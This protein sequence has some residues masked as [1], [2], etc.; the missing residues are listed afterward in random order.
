[1]SSSNNNVLPLHGLIGSEALPRALLQCLDDGADDDV[2]SDDDVYFVPPS[3]RLVVGK[4]VPDEAGAAPDVGKDAASPNE[5]DNAGDAEDETVPAPA[6]AEAEA[7]PSPDR[8]ELLAVHFVAP[9]LEASAAP[10]FFPIHYPGV[11]AKDRAD[12]RG[13]P[14]AINAQAHGADRPEV[15]TATA[16]VKACNLRRLPLYK[17]GPGA[18]AFRVV[19]NAMEVA[20][21][22][23]TPHNSLANL[24]WAKRATPDVLRTL[25]PYQKIN[26]F[27]GTW[28][29]GRKD[30]LHKNVS[31]MRRQYGAE[32]FDIVP[33]T[34]LVPNDLDLVREDC[35]VAALASGGQEPTYIVKPSASS[36][37]KG[38][39]L[40]QGVP[41]VPPMQGT[42]QMICQRYVAN[43]MI[44]HGRKFDLRVYCVITG[45]DP[46]RIYLFDEGLVRFAA[47]KYPGAD[48]LLENSNAHL[49]NYSINKASALAKQSKGKA[50]DTDEA[51]DIKWAISDLKQWLRET[52]GPAE[53]ARIWDTIYARAKDVVV[54]TFLS[55]END[56]VARIRN[57]CA[58]DPTGSRCFELYGL[59]L[60]VDDAHNVT[61]IE[62]NIMPSLAT[63]STLDKAVKARMIAHMLT[64]SGV[65][66]EQ[67]VPTAEATEE[68]MAHP[69][70]WF[71]ETRYFYPTVAG[72]PTGPAAQTNVPP[73][74]EIDDPDH[75]HSVL[76]EGERRLLAATEE[77][78]HRAG[79]FKRVFP[80]ADS[81]DR[82]APLF[83][84]GVLRS[85]YVMMSWERMKAAERKATK[86]KGE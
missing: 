84:R 58:S 76:T 45:Y 12:P 13:L 36:C 75:F 68:D 6:P 49:T 35:R 2:I 71:S 50:M 44:V 83:S 61:L 70:T 59:D 67:R 69:A 15:P 66:A 78:L 7:P 86:A 46:L 39:F 42:R 17:V 77:E 73:F 25:T 24:L 38:I 34:W 23:Y 26:H 27:P 52:H 65:F 16:Q 11:T 63:G 48:Q 20:G 19:L 47:E 1:M 79:G 55:I 54:K 18:V 29:V 62:A 30:S 60:M 74:E 3:Q 41:T 14:L 10:L 57:E 28:G 53:G 37:G 56:V 5:N 9:L 8:E 33:Q 81:F 64:L 72:A 85:N 31:R 80:C 40:A 21:M 4:Y 32:A 22:R 43:P 82:Y 51:I